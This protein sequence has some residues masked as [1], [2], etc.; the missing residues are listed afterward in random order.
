MKLAQGQVWKTTDG[1]YIRIVVW[2]RLAIEYK[3]TD[4]PD[5]KDGPVTRVTKKEFCKL[6]KGAVLHVPEPP[7]AA[8]DL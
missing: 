1:Q 5:S 3:L 4:Q 2:E 8:T 6:I 7:S